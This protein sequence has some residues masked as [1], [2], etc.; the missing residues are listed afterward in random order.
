M[1]A[2]VIRLACTIANLE[3]ELGELAERLIPVRAVSRVQ[4][5]PPQHQGAGVPTTL[6]SPMV[7][8]INGAADRLIELVNG[9]SVLKSELDI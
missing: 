3:A 2:A 6:S 7:D 4:P 1:A 5:A 9:I 8:G